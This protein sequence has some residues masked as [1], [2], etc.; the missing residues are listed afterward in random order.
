[1][2][3]LT[4]DQE[5]VLRTRSQKQE[6]M[7]IT[8]E[9]EERGVITIS[10]QKCNCFQI[11]WEHVHPM[12]TFTPRGEIVLKILEVMSRMKWNK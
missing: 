7:L 3:W 10:H 12:A 1:M 11:P 4:L 6:D 9:L 5:R 2:R 8:R